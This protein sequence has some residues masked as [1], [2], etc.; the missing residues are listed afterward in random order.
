[1]R[2]LQEYACTEVLKTAEKKKIKLNQTQLTNKK[3]TLSTVAFPSNPRI[4]EFC[5]S[6]ANYIK[7]QNRN[8]IAS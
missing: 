3:K 5:T 8:I 4:K 7:I 6:I 1:M 2:I